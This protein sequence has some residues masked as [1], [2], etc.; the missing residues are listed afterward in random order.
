MITKWCVVLWDLENV[1]SSLVGPFDT[2]REAQDFE[3]ELFMCEIAT[4]VHPYIESINWMGKARTN[5]TTEDQL[6]FHEMIRELK[7]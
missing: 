6:E 4:A 3:G 1:Y 2:K 7:V 5:T